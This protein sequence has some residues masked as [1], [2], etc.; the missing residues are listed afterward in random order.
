[1][2]KSRLPA[3]L[4][5]VQSALYERALK[6][7]NEHTVHLDSLEALVDYFE[8]HVGF[9]VTPWCGRPED[10]AAV[11]ERTGGATTRVIPKDGPKPSKPCA[12]CGRPAVSEVVWAKAY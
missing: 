6:F 10:E 12:V 11:Q 4:E 2:L 3:A 1:M 7:R 9:V 5:E 8:H